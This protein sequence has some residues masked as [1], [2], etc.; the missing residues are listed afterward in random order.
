MIPCSTT[1]RAIRELAAMG[2]LLRDY[3]A[4]PVHCY[5]FLHLLQQALRRLGAL[6][7]QRRT[8][9]LGSAWQ[10]KTTSTLSFSISFLIV[11]GHADDEK[12]PALWSEEQVALDLA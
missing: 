1:T 2:F 5:V 10:I 8:D 11:S 3:C 9:S 6:S 12:R 4:S 7:H